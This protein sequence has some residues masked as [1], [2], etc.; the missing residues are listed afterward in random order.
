[1]DV[2]NEHDSII[3]HLWLMKLTGLYQ[4][5]NPKS[6]K[7]FDFNIYKIAVVFQMFLFATTIIFSIKSM[8]YFFNDLNEI[9]KYILII[10][11]CFLGLFE[12]YFLIRYSKILWRCLDITSIKFI[13]C[14]TNEKE[15][16]LLAKKKFNSGALIC[17]SLWA[18]FLSA[19]ILSPLLSRNNYFNVMIEKKKYQ[20]HYNVFNLVFPITDD[21]YNKFFSIFFTFEIFVMFNYVH[22]MLNF[23]LLVFSMCVTIIH[24]YKIIANSYQAFR[25]LQHFLIRKYLKKNSVYTCMSF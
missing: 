22:C 19:Y 25:T 11:G 15:L 23:D 21:F 3:N 20:F 16:L 6:P 12:C 24:Q 9:V 4:L 14:S 5:L 17:I 1:M 2:R 7:L 8:C 13:S 18:F 10:F